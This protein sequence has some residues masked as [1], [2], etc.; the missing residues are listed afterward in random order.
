MDDEKSGLRFYS[1][2]IVTEDKAVGTDKIK[3][4]PIEHITQLNGLLKDMKVDYDVNVPDARGVQ[5]SEKI[6]GQAWVPASWR[7][8]GDA[9]RITSPDVYAGETV[10]MMTMSNTNEYFWDKIGTEPSIRRQETVQYGFSNLK[11]PGTAFDN[12]TSYWML[13]DT[14]NKKVQ[15]H[16]SNN[17]GEPFKFDITIDTAGGSVVI[18]DDVGNFIK[19]DSANDLLSMTSIAG[20]NIDLDKGDIKIHG[21]T[22]KIDI[23]GTIDI[24]A[25]GA[26][27]FTAPATE[28]NT[29]TQHN[30]NFSV[31]GTIAATAGLKI[32]GGGGEISGD[33]KTSGGSVTLQGGDITMTGGSITANGEDLTVDKT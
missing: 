24:K 32:T 3:V 13:W 33:L 23:D 11:K 19:M 21:K 8:I 25:G 12:D 1:L 17:D 6:S 20:A 26:T 2:G 7:A 22:L 10:V 18:Q 9:N 5:Q 27:T 29:V 14:R 30:G 15:F 4:N 16:T 28:M 31:E